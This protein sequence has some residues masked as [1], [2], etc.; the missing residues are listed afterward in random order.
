M[1]GSRGYASQ[2]V[3]KPRQGAYEEIAATDDLL[4]VGTLIRVLWTWRWVV[5]LVMLLVTGTV[6]AFTVQQTP[7]YQTSIKILVGQDGG[8]LEQSQDALALQSL[9]S[10]MAVAVDS[11]PIAEAV[12]EETN[13]TLT[14]EQLLASMSAKAM[15]DTQFVEVTYTDTDPRRAQ[16]IANTIGD[17]FAKRVSES[18]DSSA[19]SA[20]VWEKAPFPHAPVSPN[21]LRRGF[22]A[23]VLGVML[24]AGMAFLLEHFNHR[25]QSLEEAEQISGVPTFGIIPHFKIRKDKK[26]VKKARHDGP[27]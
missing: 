1:L 21:L 2:M 18:P 5:G 10:T 27:F 17:V 24:G 11:R 3:T 22:L 16:L 26:R 20:T 19:L 6:V 15:P 14:P 7:Q 4:T 9:G 13:S 23:L 12:V 8:I 25:W